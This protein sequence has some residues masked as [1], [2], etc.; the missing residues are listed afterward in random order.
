MD[1]PPYDGRTAHA[2]ALPV[3]P[4]DTPAAGATFAGVL[5]AGLD[6]GCDFAAAL[7]RAAVAGSLACLRFGAQPSLP[8]AAEIAAAMTAA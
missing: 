8:T 1:G 2:A 6:A 3:I 7:A 4:V 5:A